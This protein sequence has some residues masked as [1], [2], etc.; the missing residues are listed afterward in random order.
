MSKFKGFDRVSI[1]LATYNGEKFLSDTIKSVFNQ[2]Y[3]NFEFIIVDDGSN[4]S[5]IAIIKSYARNDKRIRFFSLSHSGPT[6]AL[7]FGVSK[8]TSKWVARIDQD[9][10]WEKYKLEKQMQFLEINN[11]IILLGSSCREIDINNNVIRIYHYPTSDFLLKY[12]L[13]SYKRFF[14]HSSAIYRTSVF[15]KIGGY[16]NLFFMADDWNLWTKFAKRGLISSIDSPLV[17]IRKH[18][19]QRSF[20]D[21]GRLQINHAVASSALLFPFMKNVKANNYFINWI[22]FELDKCGYYQKKINFRIIKE[23]YL[24][25]KSF[26]NKFFIIFQYL[27]SDY[28]NFFFL[29]EIFFG[30]SLPY[31]LARKWVNT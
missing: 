4:D 8:A 2:S 19:A 17:S 12:N 1:V 5:T 10:I 23:K 9:D 13:K 15:K 7:N 30:S 20:F 29:F 26:F 16:N 25:E 18:S 22:D 6:F 24:T 27:I 21:F 14:P 31:K 3:T 28:S 11:K